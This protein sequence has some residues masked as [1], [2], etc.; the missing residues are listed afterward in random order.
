MATSHAPGPASDDRP[1]DIVLAPFRRFA[2]I[3]SSSGILLIACAVA[4]MIWANVWPEHY[5]QLWHTYLS[6]KFGDFELKLSLA[7]FINDG[8]MAIFFFVVGL[9]VKREFIA[10]ELASP[11][12]AAIPIA[13]AIGGMVVPALVFVAMNL[14]AEGDE[15]RGWAIPMATDIAFAVGIM[16]MLG[17]RVPL[18]L[19]VFVTALAIVDDIGAV[20]VIALFYTPE[21]NVTALG[22][23]GGLVVLSFIAARA[24]LRSA[25]VYFII[26]L[27]MWLMLLASGVHATIGGVLLALTIPA[28]VRIKAPAFTRFARETIDEFDAAGNDDDD[29]IV[30][31]RRQAAVQS[32]EKACEQVHAPLRRLEHGLHPIVAF[33]IVPIFALS[34]AG[35]PV[36]GNLGEALGSPLGLGIILGLVLGKPIGIALATFVAVKLGFGDLPAG[37][38]WRQIIGA[39]FLAGI[40]F[41]MSLFIANLGFGEGELL[42]YAKAGILAGSLLAGVVGFL[43]LRST[44]AP[45]D[46]S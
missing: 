28:N 6:F 4:A 10:G 20:L 30:N 11:R 42:V 18:A 15:M 36:I 8:L 12:K 13:A 31:R 27:L 39:G 9:E 21:V 45:P 23:A 37:T 41:T 2:R 5:E 26:G 46:A 35:V 22:V 40:G 3:E 32:L 16:A 34:N 25:V 19:K 14:R 1:I 43:M 17:S 44:P 38:S 7:H 29:I 24:G 33:L